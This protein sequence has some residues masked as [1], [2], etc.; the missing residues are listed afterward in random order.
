MKDDDYPVYGL[1]EDEE[2]V[3]LMNQRIDENLMVGVDWRQYEVRDGFAMFEGNQWSSEA[4]KRQTNNAM[5][6]YTI[7]RVRPVLEA[8]CGFEIQNRLEVNYLPR[9]LNPEQRG[10]N[11]ICN[12]GVR[13]MEQKAK[14]ASQRSI[15]F[16]DMLIC[17][18]GCTATN[19]NYDNNPDGEQEVR[20]VFPAFLFWD[21]SARAKNV[22]DSEYVVELK[23]TTKEQI[24]E[25]FDIDYEGD[26][27]DTGLDS[28][29]LQFFESILPV[30]T[31]GCIYEYQWRTLEPFYRVENPFKD[32]DPA[33][34]TE[35]EQMLLEIEANAMTKKFNLDPKL[36]QMFNVETAKELREL[37]DTFDS[38]GIK[39]EYSQE[40]KY[41]YYRAIVTGGKVIKKS[42]NWSQKGFSVKFM[43]G[44][45]SELTQS[46]YGLMRA[47]RDPQRMLNQAVSDYVGFLQTVPKGGVNIESDAVADLPAFLDTYAKAKDVTVY[48]PGALS[49]GKV[50]PKI[51]PPIPAGLLEMIQ[52]ADSQIMQVCGV[53]PELMG[54][55]TSKEMNSSFYRQQ[56]RQCLTTLATYF[57]AKSTYMYEQGMLNI[58]CL[59]VL[60]ENSEGRL[61]RNVLGEGD[62]EFI[63]LLKDGIAAE[64]DVIVDEV[65]AT[66]DEN[67]DT[68]MK[69]IELQQAMPDKN[70]MPIALKFA[71][72]PADVIK[73][74]EV[75]LQPAPPPQPDPLNQALLDSQAK[76]QYAQAAKLMQDVRNQQLD[77]QEKMTDIK[78]SPLK[79]MTDIQYTVAKTQSERRKAHTD[80][81][82]LIDS[83]V[84]NL[85]TIS[86]L[87]KDNN[88]RAT[89]N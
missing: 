86:N 79:N 69:L 80:N 49:G 33:D 64:Y 68:F 53:T 18:V 10:F 67:N 51:T 1:P 76:Y 65:P 66:P 30:K 16:L 5:Q 81:Q 60:V 32:L 8:I 58:D 12:N 14:S 78:F 15:A 2:I 21:V 48:N 44:E 19:M 25:E 9:L 37:K 13:Y 26:V 43:T 47:C 3:E 20:R 31:L 84:N 27:Y 63:P 34:F 62:A 38:I 45:F 6:C 82:R 74:L 50:Q 70:I 77:G 36:D 54:M 85:S 39:L 4:T 7:N 55:M 22:I 87:K 83:R 71:A 57:D 56:I 72:L 24:E 61:I 23:V 17:G 88:A 89:T 35:E 29:V 75:T 40:K 73:E 41:K 42:E 11:D 46:Y 52:Y 59:K 28:R